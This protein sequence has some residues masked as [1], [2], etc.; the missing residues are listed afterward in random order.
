MKLATFTTR[1]ANLL[2]ALTT[3]A[4]RDR[5]DEA[6][7][8]LLHELTGITVLVARKFTNDRTADG[9][10][11]AFYLTIGCVSLGI[12][13]ADI[14]H[15]DET[16]LSFLLQHGAEKTFQSGFR[17]I[18]ELASLPSHTL[19]WDFDNDPLIQ[20][21]NLKTLFYELCRADPAEAWAG[22]ADYSRE[23]QVRKDNQT[24]IDCARWLR[25]QHYAGPIRSAELDAHAVIDIALMFAILN[26]GRIVARTGQSE[27]ENLI[28]RARDNKP[29]VEA[30]WDALLARAPAD[31]HTLL[32]TRMDELK[33]SLVKKILS[34]TALKTVV[35]HIQQNFAGDEQEVDYA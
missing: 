17:H 13:Q 34:K 5:H 9:L 20:Q 16:E 3:L 35:I 27:I 11:E 6:A 10:L 1:P 18:K 15:E 26:D 4:Q 2:S 23:W 19:I 14:P 21:R 28:R 25:K 12:S 32:R 24:V 33:T 29:D 30:G 8:H 31:Y 22:D 7:H